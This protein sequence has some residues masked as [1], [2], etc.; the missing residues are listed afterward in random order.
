MKKILFLVIGFAFF[1]SSCAV[2]NGITTNRTEVVLS[3]KNF[4]VIASVQ[5]EATATYV[6]GI[7]GLA[8]K[9]LIS[10]ARTKMLAQSDIV[11]GAKAIVNETI[12]VKFSF[13]PIFRRYKVVVSGH[14]VEFTE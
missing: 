13:F 10:K 6:V 4:K 3:K 12:E 1:F 5:G 2:H 14:I 7:G 9:A 8:K 11:G